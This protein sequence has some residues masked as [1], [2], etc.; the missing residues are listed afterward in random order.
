[1]KA[2]QDY[3]RMD[4]DF[5]AEGAPAA[6]FVYRAR[7]AAQAAE[8]EIRDLMKHTDTVTEIQNTL[9]AG[10]PVTLEEIEAIGAK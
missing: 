8:S 7:V 9:R 1:M 5:G 4:H 2:S 3:F 10:I 6:R